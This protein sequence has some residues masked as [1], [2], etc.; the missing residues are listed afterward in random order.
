MA[1]RYIFI[2]SQEQ[3]LNLRKVSVKKVGHRQGYEPGHGPKHS[4]SI[5]RRYANLRQNNTLV[6]ATQ[7]NNISG[8]KR[9]FTIWETNIP[10]H[11]YS[12]GFPRWALA[13]YPGRSRD[14]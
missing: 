8:T 7:S 12:D 14:I 9:Q 3:V 1:P 6:S 5:Q 13:P 11:Y 10:I 4:L 2:R